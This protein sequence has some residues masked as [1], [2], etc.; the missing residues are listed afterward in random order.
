MNYRFAAGA[1]SLAGEDK[2]VGGWEVE[3]R[4]PCE[5][6]YVRLCAL[7]RVQQSRSTPWRHPFLFLFLSFLPQCFPANV[8]TMPLLAV[9]VAGSRTH[10]S[11]ALIK[12]SLGSILVTIT[13]RGWR[14]GPRPVT[15]AIWQL[16][17]V[18]KPLHLPPATSPHIHYP[19]SPRATSKWF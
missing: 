2:Q 19:H 3:G 9:S 11:L 17:S 4:R 13:G 10:T 7:L 16:C 12:P 1:P 18:H 6:T 14:S 15:W 8:A 5:K